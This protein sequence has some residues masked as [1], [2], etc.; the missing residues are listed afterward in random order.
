MAMHSSDA[1]IASVADTGC[2]SRIRIFSILDP[3]SASK[4]FKYLGN[5]K[6]LFLSSL[7]YEPGCSSRIFLPVP[8]PGSRGQKAPD[9]G[10]AT[11]TIALVRTGR[12]G[13]GRV[14]NFVSQW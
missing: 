12:R 4:E 2:L 3:R 1:H 14:G 11:L 5:P 9:P 8:D 6:N 10:S 13:R 7:K